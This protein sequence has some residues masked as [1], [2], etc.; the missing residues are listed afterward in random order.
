[1]SNHPDVGSRHYESW[2]LDGDL[3]DAYVELLSAQCAIDRVKSRYSPEIVA[4]NGGQFLLRR[5][6]SAAMGICQYFS[7]IEKCLPQHDKPQ[8]NY[9]PPTK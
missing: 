6:I 7:A 4:G 9:P 2:K 1:M 3:R 5:A 8:D